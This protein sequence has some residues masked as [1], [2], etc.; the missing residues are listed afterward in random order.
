MHGRAA[1][2]VIASPRQVAPSSNS[3][4]P[5]PTISRASFDDLEAVLP[6]WRA[7]FPGDE[8]AQCRSEIAVEIMNPRQNAI[9]VARSESEA[10]GFTH[11][12]L[13]A[14]ADGCKTSPVG[15]IEAWYVEEEYRRSGVG[16]DLITAA[17]N[18]ARELGCTEMGS[19]CL[20][21]NEVS[22][23]AHTAIG[24]KESERLIAFRKDL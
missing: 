24:Y 8:E 22:L 12:G 23:A 18:W 13:R 21:D 16:A 6:L 14:Y 2:D 15:Y 7:L 19:D 9:F 17:E 3:D 1:D 11:V 4:M 20:L 10:I 5:D